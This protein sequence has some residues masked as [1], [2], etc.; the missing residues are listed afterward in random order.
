[1]LRIFISF[2]ILLQ[3]ICY[4]FNQFHQINSK[5][6]KVAL[7]IDRYR[8][9]Y[10]RKSRRETKHDI[11]PV[12]SI[13]TLDGITTAF[14]GGT[15]GV[16]SVMLLLEIKKKDDLGLESCP[17]CMGNGEIL[18]AACCAC[19]GVTGGIVCTHSHTHTLIHSYTHTL[20]QTISLEVG[21]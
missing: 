7:P 1:M 4:A 16:M 5:Q 6:V 12:A 17:Y 11:V 20:M 15:V 13:E 10:L 8:N 21:S 2:V 19:A 18:C 3:S 14:I 9:G